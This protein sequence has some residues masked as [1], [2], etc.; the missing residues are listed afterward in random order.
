VTITESSLLLKADEHERLVFCS[1]QIISTDQIAVLIIKPSNGVQNANNSLRNVQSIVDRMEMQGWKLE[2]LKLY[3]GGKSNTAKIIEHYPQPFF[4][5]QSGPVVLSAAERKSLITIWGETAATYPVYHPLQLVTDGKADFD[6]IAR[7]WHQGR[8]KNNQ[9]LNRGNPKGI[10]TVTAAKHPKYGKRR[11]LLVK[12]DRSFP[13]ERPFF[14]VNGFAAELI[15]KFSRSQERIVVMVLGRQP[16]GRSLEYLREYVVGSTNPHEAQ[17]GSIRHDALHAA[18]Q[19]Y[20]SPVS[21][22]DEVGIENNVVHFSDSVHEAVRELAL[23]VPEVL[24]YPAAGLFAPDISLQTWEGL[25]RRYLGGELKAKQ[26]PV[27]DPQED[28]LIQWRE[29]PKPSE[30]I[31]LSVNMMAGGSGG[32]FFGYTLPE[33]QRNKFLAPLVPI[34]DQTFSFMELQLARLMKREDVKRVTVIGAES[35][36][37]ALQAGLNDLAQK[38]PLLGPVLGKTSVLVRRNV[39]R[40]VPKADDLLADKKFTA[41]CARHS[42]KAAMLAAKIGQNAGDILYVNGAI[43]SKPPGHLSVLLKYIHSGLKEDLT[44]GIEVAFFHIG[45][46]AAADPDPKLIAEAK[47]GE[48]IVV[49]SVIRN[50]K[51]GPGYLA[52]VDGRLQL[53]E[54][55]ANPG[56]TV[57]FLANTC[58]IAINTQALAAYLSEG[59]D[60]LT[61]SEERLRQTVTKRIISKLVPRLEIK[62]LNNYQAW[63]GQFAYAIGDISKVLPTAFVDV[64]DK[65][66]EMLTFKTPEELAAMLPAIEHIYTPYLRYLVATT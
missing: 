61:M 34:A 4:D 9:L 31:P 45:E 60:F 43:A 40:I 8:G 2:A 58:R 32:R 37:A 64:S 39:P 46:D 15:T 11:L 16:E 63:G 5:G 7:V 50:T 6:T 28:E 22:L 56:L 1:N 48:A 55:S 13:A 18:E 65:S 27:T 51:E 23:W 25:R 41:Y 66:P 17:P 57:P 29:L 14:I 62:P 10:N 35:T 47:K 36:E 49:I 26:S 20:N 54:V 3:K 59:Q 19:A 33:H 21:S 52:K 53:M 44:S 38:A 12:D 42:H 24:W 30:E